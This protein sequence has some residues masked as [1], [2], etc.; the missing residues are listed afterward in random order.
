MGT[1]LTS[2]EQEKAE[3]L[4]ASGQTANYIAKGM[5]RNRRTVAKF[6]NE[7]DVRQKVS[8]QREVLAE[9]FSQA[10]DRIVSS[11]TPED[12]SKATLQQKMIA[13]GVAVDKAAILRDELP[14]TINLSMVWEVVDAIRDR[15]ALPQ[16]APVCL[17]GNADR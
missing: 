8:A 11:I 5:G 7:P 10:A 4:A 6:L 17:Q 14:P 1:I 12:I 2:E 9:K 3:I 15:D 13:A 16:A